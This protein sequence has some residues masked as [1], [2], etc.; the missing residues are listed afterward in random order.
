MTLD[1]SKEFAQHDR[2]AQ[3]SGP[4][5]YFAKPYFAWQRGTN[6]NTNGL[7]RQFVPKAPT[8]PALAAHQAVAR[9]ER[10]FNQRPHVASII[11]PP[12]KFLHQNFVAIHS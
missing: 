6:E 11:E 7:L 2:L 3:K 10:Q 12:R 1:N 5:V 9:M 4:K 8:S